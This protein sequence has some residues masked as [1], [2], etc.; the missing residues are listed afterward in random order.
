MA[1]AHI[2]IIDHH[3][4]DAASLEASLEKDGYTVSRASDGVEGLVKIDSLQPDLVISEVT[5]PR[6]T[7]MRLVKAVKGHEDTSGIPVILLTEKSDA[8]SMIE[9]INVGAKFYVPKP[10][11]YKTLSAKIKKV[12]G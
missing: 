7:G 4:S 6:L 1:N 2:L 10:C 3:D 9:G 5:T 11:E 12:V 8:R